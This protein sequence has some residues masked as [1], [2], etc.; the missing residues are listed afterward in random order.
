M[1]TQI[2][3]RKHDRQAGRMWVGSSERTNG[4]VNVEDKIPISY[5]SA[6]ISCHT[7]QFPTSRSLVERKAKEKLTTFE[8]SFELWPLA[9]V[10]VLCSSACKCVTPGVWVM[11]DICAFG[12]V[13]DE[14]VCNE[15]AMGM[16][17][18]DRCTSPRERYL[19]NSVDRVASR[20]K[21]EG[22]RK[23]REMGIRDALIED[24]DGGGRPKSGRINNLSPFLDN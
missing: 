10:G 6:T 13:D 8:C 12:V 15:T 16:V 3:E 7:P 22:E 9:E 17:A 21:M 5:I 23:R 1:A 4:Q 18:L 14:V 19:A 24:G 11:E 20:L 2:I